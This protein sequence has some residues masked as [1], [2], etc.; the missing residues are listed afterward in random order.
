MIHV[1]RYTEDLE[2]SGFTPEQAKKSVIIWM[3]LMDQNFATKSD[4]REQNLKNEIAL[5]ALRSEL[6]QDIVELRS[7]LKHD[8]VD[9]RSEL[10][11]DIVDLRSELKQDISNVRDEISDL[12]TEVIDLRTEVKKLGP[13]L[14]IK[15]GVMM[16]A[17][18]GAMSAIIG[19]LK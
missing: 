7:E 19:L 16:V 5:S 9:L 18:V 12:R 2:K 10:K 14:T 11:Q 8:I 13:D 6:K 3:E 17:T 1:L 4:Y 15:L